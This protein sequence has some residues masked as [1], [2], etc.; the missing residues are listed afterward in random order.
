MIFTNKQLD[1]KIKELERLVNESKSLIETINTYHANGKVLL[2]EDL[3]EVVVSKLQ[4]LCNDDNVIILHSK[5][6]HRIEIAKKQTDNLASN[7]KKSLF[8][9]I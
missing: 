9:V 8:N 6:G 1:E 7:K 2:L 3:T 5:D 4:S